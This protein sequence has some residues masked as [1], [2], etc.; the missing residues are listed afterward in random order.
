LV[1]VGERSIIGVDLQA[2]I[3]FAD[4]IE[5]AFTALAVAGMHF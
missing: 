4:D 5:V 1:N 3:V 2:P